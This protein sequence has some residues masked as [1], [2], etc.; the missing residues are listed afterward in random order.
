MH[1]APPPAGNNYGAPPPGPAPNRMMMKPTNGGDAI[2]RW[3]S[4]D[5]VS[6]RRLPNMPGQRV[7]TLDE[8]ECA[9]SPTAN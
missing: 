6:D 4:P 9:A 5:L 8:I 1:L 3:F 2:A 7:M